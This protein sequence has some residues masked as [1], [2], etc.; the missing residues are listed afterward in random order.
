MQR[1]SEPTSEPVSEPVSGRD[2]ERV[3]DRGRRATAAF[4]AAELELKRAAAEAKADM[5]VV[6]PHVTKLHDGLSHDDNETVAVARARSLL[7]HYH[8]A[9]SPGEQLFVGSVV[10][11]RKSRGGLGGGYWRR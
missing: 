7:E 5:A 3:L 4:D 2:M 6:A 11:E 10:F 1:L 8:K 9:M